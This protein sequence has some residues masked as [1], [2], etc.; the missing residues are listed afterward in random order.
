MLST[1]SHDL[2]TPLTRLRLRAERSEEGALKDGMLRDIERIDAMIGETLAYLREDARSEPESLVDLPSL[3]QTVCSDFTDVGNTVAYQGPER[4]AFPCRPGALTRAI[5][6]VVE[7]GTKFASSVVVTL[8]I[9]PEGAPRIEI[10][11]DGPGIPEALREKALEP[12]FKG[13]AARTAT[14]RAGFGLGL[15]IANDVVRN[16]GGTLALLD[17]RPSG[18]TLRIDL[19]ARD[20]RGANAAASKS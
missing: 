9:G 18:L 6:N 10:S 15:S 7:N 19:P 5:T 1:I 20:E 8:E 14:A 3:L 4:F 11:D 2:K 12:F 13:D 17:G 16:H